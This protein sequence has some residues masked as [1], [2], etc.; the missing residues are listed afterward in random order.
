MQDISKAW[1]RVAGEIAYKLA[2]ENPQNGLFTAIISIG[3]FTHYL[4]NSRNDGFDWSFLTG[5]GFQPFLDELRRIMPD[6]AW[7]IL[8]EV[9]LS[10]LDNIFPHLRVTQ[11]GMANIFPRAGGGATAW[12]DRD[13]AIRMAADLL[14]IATAA[15]QLSRILPPSN[16]EV[17]AW[18][19]ISC[20]CGVDLSHVE[21]IH[22]QSEAGFIAVRLWSMNGLPALDRL[23]AGDYSGLDWI[24]SHRI[25]SEEL[26]D[27]DS[28]PRGRVIRAADILE[29][30]DAF[31]QRHD[32]EVSGP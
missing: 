8:I 21:A 22:A 18:S 17:R 27:L 15:E 2:K 5:E 30:M 29:V 12:D 11:V 16:R 31:R 24:K 23:E 14:D 19:S 13:G 1:L 28:H 10:S 4:E 3:R 26:L 9:D 7:P 32:M 6:S 20:S 25:T